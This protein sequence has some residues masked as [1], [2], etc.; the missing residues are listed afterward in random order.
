MR[1]GSALL[2]PLNLWVLCLSLCTLFPWP[3]RRLGARQRGCIKGAQRRP[4][5]VYR[6]WMI[7]PYQLWLTR[8]RQGR[9]GSSGREGR[10]ALARWHSYSG[11]SPA[12]GQA[13][14]NRTW[15]AAVIARV[16][17]TV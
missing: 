12:D 4:L 14:G 2:Y 6:Q 17:S 15:A 11:T 8:G 7:Y 13:Q 3:R 16:G 5:G 10:K 9:T 1:L